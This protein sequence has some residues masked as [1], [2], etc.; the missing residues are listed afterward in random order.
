[1]KGLKVIA[2]FHEGSN[3]GILLMKGN[4]HDNLLMT[5]NNHGILHMK[6]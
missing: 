3:H 4:P 6:V 2:T 1:M 5:G